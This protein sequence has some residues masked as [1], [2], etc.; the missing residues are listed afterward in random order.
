MGPRVRVAGGFLRED[1]EMWPLE[2]HVKPAKQQMDVPLFE[3]VEEAGRPGVV[4][5]GVGTE[6]DES[7]INRLGEQIPAGRCGERMQRGLAADAGPEELEGRVQELAC[8]ECVQAKFAGLRFLPREAKRRK[9]AEAADCLQFEDLGAPVHVNVRQWREVLLGEAGLGA[10]GVEWCLVRKQTGGRS[11]TEGELRGEQ[12]ELGGSVV[13]DRRGEQER[14]ARA[15][16]EVVEGE[17]RLRERMCGV[18][19]AEAA[20]QRLREERM[21]F[22]DRGQVLVR[23]IQDDREIER[24]AFGLWQGQ[25][26]D[27]RGDAVGGAWQAAGLGDEELKEGWKGEAL[28]LEFGG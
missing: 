6:P 13:V 25:H 7:G 10:P 2:F 27:R 9:G 19:D 24:Q 15:P 22:L 21:T 4:G 1:G 16:G 8:V 12:C 14:E 18:A 17:A 3:D 11:R 20:L 23:R 28:T 26:L 5:S